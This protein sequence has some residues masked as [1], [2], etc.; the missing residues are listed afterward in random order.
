MYKG[1]CQYTSVF[2]YKC[3]YIYDIHVCPLYICPS[4]QVFIRLNHLNITVSYSAVLKLAM[5]I[6]K[7]NEK[8][9]QEWIQSKATIKFIGDNIDAS[10]GV[11]D[12][13]ANHQKH[14]THMYSLLVAKSR[15]PPPVTSAQPRSLRHLS[16]TCFLPKE[17]D[18]ASIQ[19]NLSILVS[20]IL[21]KYIKGLQKMMQ[22]ISKTYS[23]ISI[24]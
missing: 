15:L 2:N 19:L 20:R 5:A 10:V 12:I 7:L 4:F 18:G 24:A 21:C 11:R 9:L 8:P 22:V 13:R 3:T 1:V 14:I 23:G 6:G 16:T 17:S